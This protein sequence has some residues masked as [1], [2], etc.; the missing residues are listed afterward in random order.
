MIRKGEMC[1]LAFLIIQVRMNKNLNQNSGPGN[2]KDGR[3]GKSSRIY[4]LGKREGSEISLRRC[5]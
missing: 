4:L 2:T 5:L 1:H 3:N